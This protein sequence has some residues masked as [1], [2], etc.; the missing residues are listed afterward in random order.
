MGK[1]TVMTPRIRFAIVIAIALL[2]LPASAQT[3]LNGSYD[4]TRE[5]YK[6][7][8]PSFA[9]FYKK[10][11]GKDITI[12]QSHGGS[13]KQA[14]SVIDGIEADV[15]TLALA[16]DIDAIAKAGL[17]DPNWR[18][19]LPQNSA[20]YTSTVVFL[21]R[22]GNPKNIRD[23]ADIARPGIKVIT[24]NPKTGGG[25]RWCYLA[26]YGWAL[27][28]YKSDALAREYIQKVYRNV[29]VLD[30]A[31]RG[32]TMTFTKRGIGDVM[33]C[34]ENEAYLAL[35]ELGPKQFQIVLPSIS[36]LAEPP[37]TVVDKVAAR[38]GTTTIA[39]EYL[40]Y[41][42]SDEGQ[43]LAAKH[44]FRPRKAGLTKL[45]NI[46]LFTI[47]AVFGGWQKAQAMHFADGGVFDQIF[48][49]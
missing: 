34:W 18:S 6:E 8:N 31:A 49:K 46:P 37:V 16:Y 21:V 32:S 39:Q 5:L 26:A 24:S 23:W 44:Y 45:P 30:S 38:H 17:T 12:N 27:K 36:I 19:R 47:D 4:P 29:P 7:F 22:N 25:A 2:A 40:K 1:A 28:K 41:L 15:V 35:N 11:T 13:G 42:Y 9:A 48:K 33:L 20:P 10:K 14:R 3:L 43:R